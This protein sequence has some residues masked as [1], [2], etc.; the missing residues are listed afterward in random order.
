M[1]LRR[2]AFH[3]R[4]YYTV[5]SQID[6]QGEASQHDLRSTRETG[7]I[8]HRLDVVL[9]ESSTVPRVAAALAERILERRQG[10]DPA[11]V[12]DEYA[13]D[14]GGNVWHRDPRPSEHQQ[15]AQ[16]D[17]EDE[18]EVNDEYEISEGAVD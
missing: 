6:Q 3:P 8:E 11:V 14:G 1:S 12:L 15:S 10:T 17:K 5:G 18:R 13:P 7:R 2:C 9:D 4:D 16:Y